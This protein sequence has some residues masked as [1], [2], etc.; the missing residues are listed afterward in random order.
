MTK[1][2]G[3]TGGIATGKSTVASYLQKRGFLVIDADQLVHELQQPGERLYQA[4]VAEFGVDFIDEAGSLDRAKLAGIVFSNGTARKKLSKIQDF[5]IREELSKRR[6]FALSQ[7]EQLFFMDIPLLF[8]AHYEDF[9]DEIWL[10]AVPEEV[11]LSRLMAR[12]HLTEAEAK[13]RL[14]SQWPLSEKLA[15]ADRVLDNSGNLTSLY[16]QI[17]SAL[18]VIC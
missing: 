10:V 18:E 6:K 7:A 12:N 8:E 13:K 15:L 11:Q 1:V 4:V 5:I 14:A 2:I 9:F 17:D 3:L 16:R